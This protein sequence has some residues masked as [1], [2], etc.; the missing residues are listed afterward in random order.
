M[1]HKIRSHNFRGILVSIVL[2]ISF[3]IQ[4]SEEHKN[5]TIPQAG[6]K[7]P[8]V[9]VIEIE[10]KKIE[11]EIQYPGTFD[12]KIVSTVV[13]P[14]DGIVDNF[15]LNEND[16]IT[17]NQKILIINSQDRVSLIANA[18]KK[19]ELTKKRLSSIKETIA[20]YALAKSEY[21][22]AL[23]DQKYCEKLLLPIPVIAPIS[24]IILKKYI[25]QGSVVTAKQQILTIA[26]FKSLII[27]TSVS[28]QLI[29]KI[30]Q[31]QKI[32]VKID[33]YPSIE[34][35]GI[36]V[37][38]NPQSDV[39]TRTIPLEIKVN[40]KGVKLLP[41]M[42]AMLTFITDSR[43]NAIVVPNDAILT[44]PKGDKFVF[45]VKDSVAQERI[46]NTGI[47]TKDYTEVLNGVSAG[48]ELVVLGQEMLKDK[49]KVNVQKLPV[50]KEEERKNKNKAK[51]GK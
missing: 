34:F 42:M 41:G 47:S 5:N 43:P 33:A 38:I 51:V 1:F 37:L 30:K 16:Y 6:K 10:Q 15:R 46:I 7:A 50:S 22:E 36:I 29:S 44:K 4:C 40:A 8:L 35:T 3:L 27:R 18:N 2:V 26:D 9:K 17:R 23:E 20:E 13:A 45:V 32:K 49:I 21:E 31:G 39:A 25:E 48:E 12:V 11:N 24:G 14:I 28:E 19:V